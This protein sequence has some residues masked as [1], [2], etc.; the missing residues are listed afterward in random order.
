M[1]KIIVGALAAAFAA[2]TIGV[3]APAQADDAFPS[4]FDVYGQEII[5]LPFFG[6]IRF[7]EGPDRGPGFQGV[8]GPR[9]AST[10]GPKSHGNPSAP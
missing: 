10:S 8:K 1:N 7:I 5:K 2:A 9:G 6:S 3:A 4:P